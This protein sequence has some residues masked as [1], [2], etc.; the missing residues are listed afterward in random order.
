MVT[1]IESHNRHRSASGAEHVQVWEFWRPLH[2]DLKNA[3]PLPKF[4][5][6]SSCNLV[7]VS[8][9]LV[10]SCVQVCPSLN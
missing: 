3:A 10:R 9:P 7:A 1:G 8:P 4:A 6:F 5:M 2:V